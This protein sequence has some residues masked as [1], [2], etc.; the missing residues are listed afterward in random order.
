MVEGLLKTYL[1]IHSG[2]P[3]LSDTTS[4]EAQWAASAALSIH[5]RQ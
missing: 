1:G 5:S 4:H 3:V 2:N